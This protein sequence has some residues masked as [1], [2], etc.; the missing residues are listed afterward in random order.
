MTKTRDYYEYGPEGDIYTVRLK[1]DKNNVQLH[2]ILLKPVTKWFLGF[3]PYPGREEVQRYSES[4]LTVAKWGKEGYEAY[5]KRCIGLYN[6]FVNEQEF[7][8]ELVK[9]VKQKE[10]WSSN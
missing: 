2:C 10:D 5:A 4:L 6:L 9:D 3:I 7:L 1:I 8:E